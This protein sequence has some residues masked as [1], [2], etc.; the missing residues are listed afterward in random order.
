MKISTVILTGFVK[1]AISQE[2]RRPT[3][4]SFDDYQYDAQSVFTNEFESPQ[5]TSGG[6]SDLVSDLD[7]AI[8]EEVDFDENASIF[9]TAPFT[10]NNLL[11]TTSE[12]R[13]L[14]A[15]EITTTLAEMFQES[16]KKRNREVASLGNQGGLRGG[17]GPTNL[18]QCNVCSGSGSSSAATYSSCMSSRANGDVTTCRDGEICGVEVRMR[19]GQVTQMSIRCMEELQCLKNMSQ[20]FLGSPWR[21]SCRPEPQLQ[22]GRFGQ[23]ICNGC[24]KAC[25]NGETCFD[26]T[27]AFA[28]G[29]GGT[30][31]LDSLTR[32]DWTQGLS[33]I[34]A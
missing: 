12:P 14:P 7:Y 16:D 30:F 20:N 19:G 25:G 21:A 8:N 28:R 13:T 24:L 31:T 4:L 17:G 5:F 1:I 15:L 11:T 29:A 9:S 33:E 18:P 32:D 34:Q 23:S 10:V 2:E 3:G 26:P 6:F 27:Q 22:S